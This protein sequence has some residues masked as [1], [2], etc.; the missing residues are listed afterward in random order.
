MYSLLL[1]PVHDTET[2]VCLVSSGKWQQQEGETDLYI[3][4]RQANGDHK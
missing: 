1:F 4:Q 3:N 2:Y